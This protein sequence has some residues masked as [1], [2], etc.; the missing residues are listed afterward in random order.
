MLREGELR[1]GQYHDDPDGDKA[2]L[3]QLLS[4]DLRTWRQ[5]YGDLPFLASPAPEIPIELATQTPPKI[6]V[7]LD[8]EWER[9]TDTLA[10][11]FANELGQSRDEYI[12]RIPRFTSQP[13]GRLNIPVLVQTPTAKLTL[14][15]MLDI[16]GIVYYGN[17]DM[18]KDWVGD[19]RNF[20]TPACSYATWLDDGNR[21]LD[22]SVQD[23]RDGLDVG[24]R[25]GTVLDGVALY[26]KDRDILKLHFLDLPGSQIGSE[27]GSDR[28]PYLS[29]WFNRPRLCGGWIDGVDPE[30]G[31]VVAGRNIVTR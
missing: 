9:Q 5:R 15:R 16:A 31:S 20:R 14:A 8:K 27:I 11:L 12:A 30:F 18:L 23:V 17:L 22:R 6:T 25:G 28:S 1:L 2:A 19:P 21:N 10:Y 26:L 13:S 3:A 7:D 24:E 29:F 4:D